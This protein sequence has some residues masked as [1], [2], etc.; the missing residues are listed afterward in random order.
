MGVGSHNKKNLK[1][2]TTADKSNVKHLR[3]KNNIWVT[4]DF[5]KTRNKPNTVSMLGEEMV[6]VEE[7][8]YLR[9]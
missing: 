9:V 6:V 1:K 5:R 4:V 3:I 8:K 7:Y 2:H